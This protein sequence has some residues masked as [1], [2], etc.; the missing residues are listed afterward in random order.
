MGIFDDLKTQGAAYRLTEEALYAEALREVE[1]GRRRDGIWAMALVEAEMDQTKAAAKYIKMRVQSLR[2]EVTLQVSAAKEV[3]R[4]QE[5]K[6]VEM[7]DADSAR[8]PDCGGII[9]RSEQGN[10][11]TWMCRKCRKKGKFER[12]VTYGDP[13]KR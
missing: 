10:Y 12:G 7:A 1:S 9:D 4:K 5:L 6:R 11:V 8:H 3:S 2:D 13:P